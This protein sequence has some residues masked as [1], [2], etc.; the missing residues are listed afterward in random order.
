VGKG[1]VFRLG[2]PIEI[3]TAPVT[4]RSLPRLGRV[5]GVV[6]QGPP[7]RILVVDDDEDN[8]SWLRQL[9]LQV[10]FDVREATNGA[11]A[12]AVFDQGWP[13]LVLLDM[14]MPVMDGYAAARA[15][16]A[17]RGGRRVVIVAVTASAFDEARE[18]IFEA[19]ADGWLRKPCR[20]ADLLEEIRRHLGLEYRYVSPPRRSSSA[21]MTA[22][23]GRPGS[24]G[25]LPPAVADQLRKAAHIADYG[26][27]TDLIGELSP[28]HEAVAEE[29]R[30]LVETFAYDKI[31]TALQ[32]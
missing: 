27:L 14:N 31:E 3:G 8:R 11:E 18:A 29:L 13:Q 5:V 22:I 23:H 4:Q 15:I 24:M 7:V 1:S 17:R 26:H 16:R 20:E 32:P 2:I 9:L 6:G 30:R 21:T 19:G 25:S 12:V 10:G 28:E